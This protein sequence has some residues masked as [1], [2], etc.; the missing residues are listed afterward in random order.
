MAKRTSTA[1]SARKL[2]AD[3]RKRIKEIDGGISMHDEAVRALGALRG[4]MVR[5]Q[6]ARKL[7]RKEK[8]RLRDIDGAL[9]VF[10]EVRREL[11]RERIALVGD[12]T[13]PQTLGDQIARG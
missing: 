5:L 4:E 10:E 13:E 11:W 7:T 9:T 2:S 12:T 8:A 6:E 3:D 1:R